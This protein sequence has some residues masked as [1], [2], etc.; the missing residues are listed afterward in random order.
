ML[1]SRCLPRFNALLNHAVGCQV[2][3]GGQ[4][5]QGPAQELLTAVPGRSFFP[6]GFLWDEGF[7]Q[8]R[9]RSS[10]FRVQNHSSLSFDTHELVA[11]IS[12][13]PPADPTDTT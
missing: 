1:C 2:A 8:V 11:L 9:P 12:T 7:H 13:S 4:V 3:V 5:V 10:C 6:R